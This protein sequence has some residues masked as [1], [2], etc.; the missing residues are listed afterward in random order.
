MNMNVELFYLINNGMSNPFFDFVMPAIT[1][2]GGPAFTTVA[3][4]VLLVLCWKD[5]FGL[6]KYWGLVKLC[7][8]S[9]LFASIITAGT[10]HFF[11]IPR[12][13]MVLDHVNVLTATKMPNS[14][15]SGH[16]SSTLS[17]MTVVFL[18]AEKYFTRYN[19]VKAFCVIFS[20]LIAFSRIYVGMHYPFDVM[21]GGLIGMVCGVLVCRYLKV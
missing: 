12:P 11:P 8:I 14:F 1:E 5:V 16:T 15:P 2:L 19:L 21:V 20:V 3:V 9:L 17:I 6:G 13:Y 4:V 18:S 10:K 7:A